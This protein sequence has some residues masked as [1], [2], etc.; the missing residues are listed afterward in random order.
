MRK[1]AGYAWRDYKTYTKT[2]KQ[3]NITAVLDKIQE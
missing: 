2:V 3:L 1:I